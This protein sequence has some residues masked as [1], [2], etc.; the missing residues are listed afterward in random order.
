MVTAAAVK[1]A[2]ESEIGTPD[3]ENP[4]WLLPQTKSQGPFQGP[5]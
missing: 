4:P 2:R 5:R 3:S 1:G